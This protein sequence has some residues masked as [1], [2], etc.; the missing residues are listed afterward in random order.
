MIVLGLH[1]GH[2]GSVCVVKNGRLV[3]AMSYERLYR[4]KKAHG[5]DD[6]TLDYVLA[7]AGVTLDQVD[8]IALSDWH[9]KYGNGIVAVS[10]DG[11]PVECTWNA[12]FGNDVRT[13]DA[14][15]RGR[16]YPAFNVGH[17][18]CHCAAAYYTS[19]FDDSICLS[20][21]SSGGDVR[22]N[23]AVAHGQGNKIAALPCPGAMVGLVYGNVCERLGLGSQM[24]KAGAMMGLAA[25]GEPWRDC[26][27]L[28]GAMCVPENGEYWSLV[29]LVW[30]HL[31]GQVA[32]F[33]WCGGVDRNDYKKQADIAA[34]MQ[35]LFEESILGLVRSLPAGPIC[36]GGGSFLNCSINSRIARERQTHLFPAASDD[37]C[38]VGAAL[39]VAHH[40]HDEPRPKYTDAEI[41]YLGPDQVANLQDIS[42]TVSG[43]FLY[44]NHSLSRVAEAIAAGQIVGWFHGLAECGPRALGN[45]SILADPRNPTHRDYINEKIKGREWFRPFAPTALSW[46]SD[47]WFDLPAPSPFML[48]T[49]KV[50]EEGVPAIT[51]IDGSARPQT[52]T[53]EMNPAYYDL[54]FEFFE[55]TGIPMLLNTSLNGGGL[56]IVEDEASVRKLW[57]DVPLDLL[58]YRGEIWTR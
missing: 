23:S 52:L 14:E 20:M 54:I 48:M 51:H 11:V 53:R 10:K 17:H 34:S 36:L 39:Y 57:E 19:P 9:V 5:F 33:D 6:A 27:S 22:S 58:V 24:F 45:R 31:S 47:A 44:L 40:I 32:P 18:M 50:K 16:K 3:C 46:A 29:D 13:F 4:H 41:A 30:K 12:V 37:G 26:L 15:I 55:I 1:T 21:D 35:L 25:Y 42:E 56:P 7:G 2:D 38:A 49:G 28:V 43:K 8:A